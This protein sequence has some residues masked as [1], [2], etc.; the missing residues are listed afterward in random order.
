MGTM[1]DGETIYNLQNPKLGV[2]NSTNGKVESV[3]ILQTSKSVDL[4]Y[5]T[6]GVLNVKGNFVLKNYNG[7][8]IDLINL[9]TKQ[10]KRF[11]V[12]N[13]TDLGSK[14]IE[15]SSGGNVYTQAL[16]YRPETKSFYYPRTYSNDSGAA[17]VGIENF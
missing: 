14:N 4:E 3:Q 12:E 6:I 8:D 9:D 17:I 7:Y 16:L 1:I 11:E 2:I 10:L 5:H 13:R 15:Y